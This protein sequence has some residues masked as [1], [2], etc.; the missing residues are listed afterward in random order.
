[1]VFRWN[2]YGHHIGGDGLGGIELEE[3]DERES[4]PR[5]SPNQRNE[6][7]W[8][9]WD[10]AAHTRWQPAAGGGACSSP[11]VGGSELASPLSQSL[12]PSRGSGGSRADV[13]KR[14]QELIVERAAARRAAARIDGLEDMLV[15]LRKLAAG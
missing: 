7:G 8:E 10:S 4:T 12:S 6:R 13:R 5:P 15:K 9:R 14:V 11:S 2:A 1:M 3:R